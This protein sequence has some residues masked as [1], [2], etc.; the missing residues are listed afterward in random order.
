MSV[1]SLTTKFRAP[2]GVLAALLADDE[3]QLWIWRVLAASSTSI[4]DCHS[5][6]V[7]KAWGAEARKAAVRRGRAR[8]EDASQAWWAW[9]DEQLRVGAGA[10]HRI[11]KRAAI[12]APSPASGADGPS[13]AP[14]RLVEK[15]G[16]DWH[17]IWTKFEGVA[18]APWRH[19]P[20]GWLEA[21]P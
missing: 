6:E 8:S 14:Q 19:L 16:T 18:E 9:V 15:A 12:A 11:S 10:L 20:E 5:Q 7:L 3:G 17:A 2:T 1:L 4:M 13:L 21:L